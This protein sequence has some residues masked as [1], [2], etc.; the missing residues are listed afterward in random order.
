MNIPLPAAP[1]TSDIYHQDK[2]ELGLTE[3]SEFN[4]EVIIIIA[5]VALIGGG[6]IYVYKKRSNRVGFADQPVD[7]DPTGQEYQPS[8]Q[9]DYRDYSE[10]PSDEGLVASKLESFEPDTTPSGEYFAFCTRCGNRRSTSSIE[11]CTK[12][13]TK[14]R[15]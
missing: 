5:A 4:Y 2:V 10:S 8:L 12:C 11:F 9:G 13:G 1:Y 6:G 3:S 14:Y 15:S 7:T